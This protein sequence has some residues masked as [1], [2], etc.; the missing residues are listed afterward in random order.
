MKT[1]TVACYKMSENR[2][3]Y[4]AGRSQARRDDHRR[5]QAGSVTS[6]RPDLRENRP[7]AARFK[8]RHHSVS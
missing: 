2:K 7:V 4:Q 8:A 6:I 3:A 5:S 1:Y